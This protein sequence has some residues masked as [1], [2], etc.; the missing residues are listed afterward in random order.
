MIALLA[1]VF[2]IAVSCG[3]NT[4]SI[5]DGGISGSGGAIASGGFSGSGGPTNQS[6]G[7]S[8]SGGLSKVT[9][10]IEDI[11]LSSGAN[12]KSKS[13]LYEIQAY[14]LN[15]LSQ[16][17]SLSLSGNVF[18]VDVQPGT[19]L[20][21]EVLYSGNVILKR[22]LY[23]F[24]TSS[25]TNKNI[26]PISHLLAEMVAVASEGSEE[27]ALKKVKKEIFNNESYDEDQLKDTEVPSA[28]S[29]IL[30]LSQIHKELLQS[31]GNVHSL[32]VLNQFSAIYKST[33]VANIEEKW[34]SFE[35]VISD[36]TI[37]TEYVKVFENS[38]SR[39]EGS[40]TVRSL[41]DA[42]IFYEISN[43][44]AYPEILF[45]QNS[46]VVTP[47]QEFSFLLPDVKIKD[48]QG[49]LSYRGYFKTTP[50]GYYFSSGNQNRDLTFYASTQDIGSRYEYEYEVIGNNLKS[51]KK[52]ISIQVK[53]ANLEFSRKFQLL[54]VDGLVEDI[55]ITYSESNI[56]ISYTTNSKP[57]MNAYSMTQFLENSQASN[58]IST[59]KFANKPSVLLS[60]D[61][62][63][64]VQTSDNLLKFKLQGN[65]LSKI[66]EV[67]GFHGNQMA[68][69]SAN[70]CFFNQESQGVKL[71]DQNLSGSVSELKLSDFKPNERVDNYQLMSVFGDNLLFSS[72]LQSDVF[73]ASLNY[74]KTFESVDTIEK[75]FEKRTQGK[76]VV[77]AVS[78][79]Y[80][81][82]FTEQNGIFSEFVP[83]SYLEGSE[84]TSIEKFFG[85]F[86]LAT[87]S[88]SS[89]VYYEIPTKNL[90]TL[91]LNDVDLNHQ[92]EVQN[93]LFYL[94]TK[95]RIRNEILI[96]S[97]NSVSQYYEFRVY[98]ITEK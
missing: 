14:N 56:Y 27:T 37:A 78:Q 59:F 83:F 32:T 38:K 58:A 98:K 93:S 65:S 72:S 79:G 94:K 63:V 51:S 21:I 81:Y 61:D 73:G 19:K 54:G 3:G 57:Y 7:I 47:G 8:G 95:N 53:D 29:N 24:Q 43:N 6:G 62:G 69:L 1:L 55:L 92:F 97:K 33:D 49:I 34:S 66:S 10:V 41:T 39:L 4:T 89:I 28:S 12:I 31:T 70:L 18:E 40:R 20:A 35:S 23:G 67:N 64:F 36:S 85:H 68:I 60:S 46:F 13:S 26:S 90:Q 84:N 75:A 45:D 15:D 2:A 50:N 80:F 76:N 91:L 48:K 9:G 5:T 17:Y 52:S 42:S 22:H 77:W 30:L 44:Y 88:R 96:F 11:D 82:E 25:N 74:L 87:E 16:F 71:F 86:V